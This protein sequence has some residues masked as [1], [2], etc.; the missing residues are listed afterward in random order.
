MGV[1]DSPCIYLQKGKAMDFLRTYQ[2]DLM[3]VMFGMCGILAIMTIVTGSLPRRTRA[4]LAS[5]EI[6]AALLL[7]FDRFAYL[8]RG[9]PSTMGYYMSRLGNGMVYLMS[10]LIPFLVTRFLICLFSKETNLRKPPIQLFISEIVFGVGVVMLIVAR[11]TGLYYTYDALNQYQRANW[12]VIS[13]IFPAV[14]VILQEWAI[15]QHRKKFKYRLVRSIVVAIALPTIASIVQFFLYGLSLINITTALV[16]I[17][18][19]SY[20]LHFLSDAAIEARRHEIASLKES[21]KKELALFEQTTEAL[22]NAIDAK[23]KY[24]SGHS[25]RVAYYSRRI[26]KAAGFIE[27]TCREVYFAALLHDVGKIG[28][29]KSIINKVGKLTPEEYDEIKTHPEQGY[30]ILSSIKQAPF[31]CIGARYHHE[32]YDGKGYPEGLAGE[33]IPEIA[34]I[35]AVADA[36]DAMTSVRSYRDP[37]PKEIVRSELVKGIGTQFDPKFATIMLQLLDEEE[38]NANTSEIA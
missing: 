22:A 29:S 32:R 26:A 33:D 8:Y 13:Y 3:L 6:A 35:I 5:M 36:Y 10:L 17:V 34:R 19:Y 15:I 28:V 7:L 27:P 11:Y 4:T 12:N 16:V 24:T 25:M 18:F 37:L 31:L 38:D 21:Q 30:Q 1:H 2:L 9:D 20:V 14:I 23:D